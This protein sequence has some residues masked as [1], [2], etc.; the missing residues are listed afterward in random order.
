MNSPAGVSKSIERG[1]GDWMK[2]GEGIGQRTRVHNPGCRQ[3]CGD[4]QRERG[5]RTAGGGQRGGGGGICQSVN[6]IN[7]GKKIINKR[8]IRI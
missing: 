1:R 4:G 2:G 8:P 5:Q 3:E 7:K 6:N